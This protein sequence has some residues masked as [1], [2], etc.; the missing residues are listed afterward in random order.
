[1]PLEDGGSGDPSPATAR[2]VVAA[3]RAVATRLWGT[4]D[5]AGRTVAVQGVGK[6]GSDL[7]GRLVALGADVVA[8]D[9][10]QEAL[11][12]AAMEHGVKVVGLDDIYDVECD[13]FAPCAMGASLNQ[14]TIPRLNCAAV[15]GSA[16]NQLAEVEDADRLTARGILYAPDFV[17]NA[18]G[19]IAI[20]SGLD[21]YRPEAADAA[22]DRIQEAVSGILSRAAERGINPHRAAEEVAEER[23]ATVDPGRRSHR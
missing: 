11:D 23:M 14:A 21:G 10:N 1:M 15:V 16:N 2:G 19:I 18:G 9:A 7:V 22:V 8:T 17:V 6:V 4:E 13:I 5:L 3:M 12:A 20:A